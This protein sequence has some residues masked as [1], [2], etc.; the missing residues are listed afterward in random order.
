MHRVRATSWKAAFPITQGA[1]RV[2]RAEWEGTDGSSLGTGGWRVGGRCGISGERGLCPCELTQSMPGT[3]SG[4]L[5]EASHFPK[6]TAWAC[7]V[8]PGVVLTSLGFPKKLV[9]S[10]LGQGSTLPC[11]G[12]ISS[13]GPPC[14]ASWKELLGHGFPPE[15]HNTS[16]T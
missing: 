12:A 7:R 9:T 5:L 8:G 16:A 11:A 4:W 3:A 14:M 2:R 10:C 6:D 13:K 1:A 15:A